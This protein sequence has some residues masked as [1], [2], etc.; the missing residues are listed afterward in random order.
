MS[1]QTGEFSRGHLETVWLTGSPRKRAGL[2]SHPSASNFGPID[3][4]PLLQPVKFVY[5]GSGQEG[6]RLPL[7]SGEHPSTIDDKNRVIIPAKM[8][9]AAGRDGESGFYI[10]RGIDDCITIQTAARFEQTS[11]ATANDPT[12]QTATGR[13]IERAIFSKAEFAMCDK[14]GRLLIPARLIQQ[15]GISRQVVIVG[16]NDRIEVWDQARWADM[17]KEAQRQLEQRAEE[18]YRRPGEA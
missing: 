8:R 9:L 1:G 18:Y 12:R 17:D 15:L 4:S 7:F 10:T 3:S 13:M 2:Y 11:A 5:A 14:Q 6:E 16:V